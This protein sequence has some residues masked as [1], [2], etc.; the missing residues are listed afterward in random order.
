M[1]P[2]EKARSAI[3]ATFQTPESLT[4]F[5]QNS[6]NSLICDSFVDFAVRNGLIDTPD[7]ES[8]EQFIR[9][10]SPG[11]AVPF[12]APGDITFEGLLNNKGEMLRLN[13]SLRA[14]CNRINTILTAYKIALPHVTNSMLLRLKKEPLDT[15]YKLNVVR[16][17][18][19]WLGHERADISRIWNFETLVKLFPENSGSQKNGDYSEGV[20]I[21]FAL[22]SRGE[23]V[24]H[25]II[26]W[27]KKAIKGYINEA[28][29]HFLYGKWGKSQSI[30]FYDAVCGPPEREGRRQSGVLPGMPVGRGQAGPSDCRALGDLE[31]CKQQPIFY[32]WPSFLEITQRWI[33]ISFLF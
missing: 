7:V 20:R 32:P 29:S 21:G 19:F 12:K 26:G 9:N 3:L 23:V 1:T 8:L 10:N 11:D 33:S 15:A 4:V 31:I 25:E 27:L 2:I 5:Y 16:S 13:L 17:M 6:D 14:F 18:A 30:R 22:T 24:D 28:I